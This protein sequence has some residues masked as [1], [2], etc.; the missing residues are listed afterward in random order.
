MNSVSV[1]NKSPSKKQTSGPQNQ[2]APSNVIGISNSFDA[3]VNEGEI[4]TKDAENKEQYMDDDTLSIAGKISSTGGEKQQQNTEDI[5]AP[6]GVASIDN[7]SAEPSQIHVAATPTQTISNMDLAK[8]VNDAPVAMMRNTSPKKWQSQA[9]VSSNQQQHSKNTEVRQ[10]VSKDIIPFDAQKTEAH[11]SNKPHFSNPHV[12]QIIKDTQNAMMMNSS[13]VKQPFVTLNTSVFEIPSQSVESFGEFEGESGQLMLSTGNNNNVIQ[14]KVRE[15]A[16]KSKLWLDQREEDDEEDRGDGFYG[17]SSEETDHEVDQESAGEEFDSLTLPKP[18]GLPTA[19][20][21]STLNLNAPAFIPRNSP[22]VA[23]QNAAAGNVVQ[24]AETRNNQNYPA[25]VSTT[26]QQQRS[27]A[28]TTEAN[29]MVVAVA[30]K[31]GQHQQKYFASIEAGQQMQIA[32]PDDFSSK[33]RAHQG[34][35]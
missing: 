4:S 32:S 33:L 15:M 30:S 19:S 27:E 18:D 8:M 3:L 23:R 24:N 22:V 26:G 25:A 31:S 34:Q 16:I 35:H 28:T 17:Y 21:K 20:Q 13:V 29:S 12:Q 6:L 2:I 1:V 11:S 9:P 14:A 10:F 5:D 7:H